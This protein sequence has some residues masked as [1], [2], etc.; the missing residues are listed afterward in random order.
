MDHRSNIRN[1]HPGDREKLISILSRSEP[2]R[3]LGYSAQDW[4][5]LFTIVEAGPP[6][7][8]YVI[9]C[10]GQPDGLAVVR[11][12]FLFGDY[13]ELLAVSPA[14][15]GQGLGRLLLTHVEE[16]TFARA[17]NLFACV[18]DF[19]ADARRFYE[20]Q[21]YAEVGSLRNLLV[22]GRDEILLRKT[23]GPARASGA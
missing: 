9:E 13:L 19:N 17:N 22:D 20:H 1:Y 5:K 10:D 3:T 8:A 4:D 15:R 14:R 11:R 16:Q 2:W 21:G 12:R 6:R 7:E 18:S 23:T